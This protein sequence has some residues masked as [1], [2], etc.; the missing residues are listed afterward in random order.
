MY[1]VYDSNLNEMKSFQSD[2]SLN[3]FLSNWLQELNYNLYNLFNDE[4]Y[5]L[6]VF[7]VDNDREMNENDFELEVTIR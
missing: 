4:D 5:F 7:D 2:E 6:K 3:R 1:V